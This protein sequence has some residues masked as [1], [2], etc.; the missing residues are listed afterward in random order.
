VA[1]DNTIR[2][3]GRTLQLLPGLQRPSYAHARV[4]VQERL[5]GS[6]VVRY[7]GQTIASIQAPDSPVKLRARK[8]HAVTRVET[9]KKPAP[10]ALI[11]PCSHQTKPGPNHPWRRSLRVT[12]S[13]NR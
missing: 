2:F 8:T 6:L 12:K 10:P 3:A 9:T 4:E 13:L 11:H 7:Q 1:P 5:D